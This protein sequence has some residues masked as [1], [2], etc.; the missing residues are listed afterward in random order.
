MFINKI[1]N[2]SNPYKRFC[3]IFLIF[4]ILNAIKL[5]LFNYSMMP[6]KTPGILIYKLGFF[7]LA[8]ALVFLIILRFRSRYVYLILYI[9]ESI[10]IFSLLSYYGY[11]RNYLHI[12]QSFVLFT[13]GVE[14]VGHMTIPVG[15]THLLILV[16]TLP[17]IYIFKN[18]KAM[19]A[20]F[21]NLSKKL[22][23]YSAIAFTAFLL[24]SEGFYA[25]K[26][27]SMKVLVKDYTTYENVFV[28]RF[29]TLASD[30][31]NT[32][33]NSGGE[34]YIKHIQYGDVLESPSASSKQYN[35]IA[36]QVESLDSHIVNQTW[37]DSYVT[38]YL[39]SL[40][41]S[42]VYYPYT[43]SYHMAGGT[44]DAEFSAL[45]SVE[46]LSIFPSMKLSKYTYPNSVVKQFDDAGYTTYSFHGNIGNYYNRDVAFKKMGF[47]EFFDID[48][49]E[50]K[51]TSGWGVP[52]H[53]M[54]N[55]A[56]DKL[57]AIDGPFFSYII[58]I[59]SHM[60]FNNTKSYYSTSQ[61]DDVKNKTVRNYFTS[62][63][64]VDQSIK[65][66]VGE[67]Q[68]LYP[69]TY[70]FIYGDHTPDIDE[71]EYTQASYEF[72][73]NYYEFVPMFVITPEGQSSVEYSYA[74]S[75]LDVAPTMLRSSGIAYDYKSSGI[76]LLGPLT[77][78]PELPYKGGLYSRASLL[79]KIPDR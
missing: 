74:A 41:D 26:G 9:I 70:I 27:L 65:E 44:S 54:F 29:G 49:M 79:E 51:D 75:F 8:A 63:S 13:E 16:D 17:F 46:P 55:Y 68:K 71:D 2:E 40:T 60:P 62:L 7:F 59:T 39:H 18:Y 25:Y 42:S 10:Y 76:N 6:V 64:Y 12:M 52:D 31:F 21:M 20:S 24:I 72:E 11:F 15:L 35:I 67:I 28:E 30:S 14:S 73:G 57:K 53:L 33:L 32:I 45:N 78:I 77:N 56:L 69:D 48:D 47:N 61:F 3:Y 23:K 58:T 19:H 1:S 22:L 37:N 4:L 38:P 34:S 43:L 66:F 50:Y 5:S 36:I